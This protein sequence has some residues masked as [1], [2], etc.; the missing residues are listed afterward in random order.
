MKSQMQMFYEEDRKIG[1][2]NEL[3]MELVREGLTRR[4]L[5]IN[6]ARRPSLWGRFSNW[7]EKLP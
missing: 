1:D 7:L 4:E 3:F 2:L 5:E 6:I